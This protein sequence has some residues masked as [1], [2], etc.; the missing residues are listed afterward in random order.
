M[1]GFPYDDLQSWKGAYPANIFMEQFRKVADGWMNGLTY[2]KQAVAASD[3]SHRTI[4]ISDE[5]IAKAAYLHF[6]SVANQTA[7]I[8]NRDKLLANDL[9]S[10][11]K[12]KIREE[13]RRILNHEI[14]LASELF[15]LC[16]KDSRIGYEASNQYYYV[17][18]DLV[19]KV[20]NCN[21]LLNRLEK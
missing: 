9:S 15:E 13:I 16:G 8:I 2:F 3:S 5:H 19:E 12:S 17:Q 11:A 10:P 7:Y 20:I 1:V 6:A 18:Q 21:Y 4:A 14:Q